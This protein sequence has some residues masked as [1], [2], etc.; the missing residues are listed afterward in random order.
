MNGR[1]CDKNFGE[2]A[3]DVGTRICTGNT[4]GKKCAHLLGVANDV[5]SPGKGQHVLGSRHGNN[6][7]RQ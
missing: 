6:G 3:Y 7:R 4:A 2:R 1:F 5:V